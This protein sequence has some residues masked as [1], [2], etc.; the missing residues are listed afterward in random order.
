MVCIIRLALQTIYGFMVFKTTFNNIKV[1]VAVS[2]VP[3][4]SDNRFDYNDIHKIHD[5]SIQCVFTTRCRRGRD[6]MVISV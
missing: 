2:L 5:Q 6:R 4:S 1:I 3:L